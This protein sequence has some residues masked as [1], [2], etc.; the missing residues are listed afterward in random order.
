MGV[1]V[2][3]GVRGLKPRPLRA[4]LAW[5]L[6]PPSLGVPL[7]CPQPPAGTPAAASELCPLPSAGADQ[8]DHADGRR[9]WEGG[10][11]SACHHLYPAR[12]LAGLRGVGRDFGTPLLG[13]SL[14]P[15]SAGARTLPGVPV[16]EGLPGDPVSKCQNH[17]HVP[18]VSG[19]WPQ[20]WEGLMR[21]QCP[22]GGVVQG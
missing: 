21:R 16:E 7:C 9:D 18:P 5:C 1:R 19:Q 12:G 3:L 14:T 8:E 11:C 6:P 17:D 22:D 20:S 13:F 4:R 15:L 2:P 10:G